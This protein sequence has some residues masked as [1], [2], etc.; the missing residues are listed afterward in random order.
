MLD[1]RPLWRHRKCRPSEMSI[2]RSRVMCCIK[3]MSASSPVRRHENIYLEA[4]GCVCFEDV[5]HKPVGHFWLIEH[6]TLGG[7]SDRPFRT[8]HFISSNQ[9]L[10]KVGSTGALLQNTRW[11][12]MCCS[13]SS[14]PALKILIS[15]SLTHCEDKTIFNALIN[16]KNVILWPR[17]MRWPKISQS[18]ISG[19]NQ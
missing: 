16:R 9:P 8:A 4:N 5:S 3:F 17:H 11:G 18:Q 10:M 15:T 7:R 1:A 19:L 2:V 14:C 12:C 13:F 6:W